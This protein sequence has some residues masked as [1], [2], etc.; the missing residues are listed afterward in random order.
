MHGKLYLDRFALAES[1]TIIRLFELIQYL[2]DVDLEEFTT[3]ASIM[4]QPLTT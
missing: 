3:S 4:I 2:E 1:F